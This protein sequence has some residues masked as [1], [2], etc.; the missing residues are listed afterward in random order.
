MRRSTGVRAAASDSPS[1]SGGAALA[2]A[3]RDAMAGAS[4]ARRGAG[5]VGRS[6]SSS[7]SSGSASFSLALAFARAARAAVSAACAASADAGSAPCFF[8]CFAITSRRCASLRRS[9]RHAR[10]EFKPRAPALVPAS[11]AKAKVRPKENCV[12]RMTARTSRVTITMIEPGRLR[13]AAEAPPI[14]SPV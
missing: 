2:R 4:A 12:V 13:Y 6:S 3:S 7:S 10:S 8:V 9:S 14:H 11:M 1:G 5:A